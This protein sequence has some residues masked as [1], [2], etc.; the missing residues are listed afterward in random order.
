VVLTLVLASA[1]PVHPAAT[2]TPG[3]E[4]IYAG[5][6]ELKQTGE[7]VPQTDY[8]APVTLST[9]V[10]AVD[11]T[12]GY[13]IILMRDVR[14]E[15]T[16][17]RDQIPRAAEVVS[18]RYGPDRNNRGTTTPRGPRP[19]FGAPLMP[20][21]W[22][23]PLPLFRPPGSAL[24]DLQP[25]QTWYTTE[26]LSMPGVRA[27]WVD[28]TVAGETTVAGRPCMRITLAGRELP[29]KN[30]IGDGSVDV[31]DFGG[32]V[33]VE[34]DTG[35][36]VSDERHQTVRYAVG[37][38]PYRMEAKT[39]L[40]LK[41]ARQLS[42]D[43]L[44][45]RVKQA[46]AIAHMERLAFGEEPG[47]SRKQQV[48]EAQQ[49]MTQ[50]RRD[51]PAS[52]YGPALAPIAAYLRPEARRLALVDETAPAFRLQDLT[53]QEKTLAAY[54]GKLILLNFFASW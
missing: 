9:V 19:I 32:T 22:N 26:H 36:V 11:P 3:Q 53:G 15:P 48:T 31:T 52:P 51:Y 40:T 8:R 30:S 17:G 35:L 41:E 43:E 7:G 45:A 50:F 10:A 54:R 12:Q 6:L 49:A 25:G 33:C 27:P 16:P 1:R 2:L 34:R 38:H 39:S 44:A 13:T 20:L 29:S 37:P 23:R 46:E 24:A 42:G 5:M 14:P 28:F 18:E 47:P 4:F 21:L